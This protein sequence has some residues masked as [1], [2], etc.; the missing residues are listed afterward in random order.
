MSPSFHSSTSS[1]K[2]GQHYHSNKHVDFKENSDNGSSSVTQ[3]R[4]DK[5]IHDEVPHF[6]EQYEDK[7]MKKLQMKGINTN[8]L[9]KTRSKD[10]LRSCNDD[11]IS[12]ENV[13]KQ[14]RKTQTLLKRTISSISTNALN[15]DNN[16]NNNSSKENLSRLHNDSNK[17]NG[18]TTD[19][20][21]SSGKSLFHVP[22]GPHHH[23]HSRD[24]HNSNGGCRSNE[25]APPRK[26]SFAGALFKRFSSAGSHSKDNNNNNNSVSNT[27]NSASSSSSKHSKNL[28]STTEGTELHTPLPSIASTSQSTTTS[29]LRSQ[30]RDSRDSINLGP[31]STSIEKVP[32]AIRSK[33]ADV[34]STIAHEPETV[35]QELSRSTIFAPVKEV[36]TSST[37]KQEPP[38]ISNNYKLVSTASDIVT[39]SVPVRSKSGKKSKNSS[40]NTTGS[41][42]PAQRRSSIMSGISPSTTN[43][44][45]WA[46]S[47]DTTFTPPKDIFV[48]KELRMSKLTNAQKAQT[49]TDVPKVDIN[50]I[51]TIQNDTNNNSSNSSSSSSSSSSNNN[52]AA[53][54]PLDTNLADLTDITKTAQPKQT[55]MTSEDRDDSDFIPKEQELSAYSSDNIKEL[56]KSASGT[57][58]DISDTNFRPFGKKSHSLADIQ[59]WATNSS[60]SL[61]PFASQKST[62]E[63][64]APESW[65]VE[66]NLEK[67]R[68]K[69]KAKAKARKRRL[70]DKKKL[71]KDDLLSFKVNSNR[72]NKKQSSQIDTALDDTIS[73]ANNDSGTNTQERTRY[74]QDEYE[75]SE[76]SSSN[77]SI[78]DISADTHS[79][80]S[81]SE[82][83]EDFYDIQSD[84][85]N[86]DQTP[87]KSNSDLNNRAFSSINLLS[88]NK[89]DFPKATKNVDDEKSDKVEYELERYYKDFSDLDPKRHYAIRVFNTDDTFTTLSC[90]PSTTVEEMI[91]TLKKKFNISVP[92]NYQISLK[93]GKLSK[94]LRPLSKPIL[95]E[96][97][98][99]LLNGY[100][101]S[102]PLHIIGVEDLSF[103][104]KF[105]FHPVTASH[106]TPEQ[107]KRLLRSDFVHVDLRNMNLTTPP[108]IFYQHTAEIESLDVSNNANIFL[109]LEFIESAIKLLSLRIVNVRA[110]KFPTNITEAY[111]LVSLELQRNFIK[112]VPNSIS[113]LWNLTILNLQCN[114]LDRLPQGFSQLKNLQLLD[115]SS[116]RFNRYP[117]VINNCTNLLQIDLSYNKIQVLPESINQLVKV[118]KINIS[119]NKLN[120]IND[121]SGMKNLRTLNLRFNRITSINTNA[122]N[123][124]NLFLTNNRISKFE[125]VV[126]KLRALEIQEN[127]ITI[128]AFKKFYPVDMTSLSLNNAQLASLP[129]KLFTSL[130]RLEKLELNEN[131]LTRLPSE[132]GSL[133]KLVYLSVSRNK[134]ESLPPEFKN[135]K[136]LRSLDLHSNNIRDVFNCMED[137]ELTSLNISSNMFGAADLNTDFFHGL[138]NGSKLTKSLMFFIAADNQFSDQ[139]WPLFNCFI[140][141]KLL[142]LSYNNLSDVS[143]LK[144]EN[145]TELYLSGNGL[146]TLPSD[147]VLKWKQLK[148]L[149]LNGNQL[150]SLPAELSLLRHLNTLDVGSNQLKYNISN[151]HYDW[152]WRDN[153]E[154]KYLNFSGNKRFEIR[155][156]FNSEL[157]ADM[158]D[159]TVLPQLK[160]LGLMDVT[161]NTTRVPDETSNFRLR[162]T[163]STINGMRYGVADTLGQRDYVS[164]KDV[165]F[166]RFRGNDDECLV[167]LHDIKNQNADYGHNI[168]RI[169]RDIYDKILIR[170][171]EK[172]GDKEDDDIRKALR[173]SFLQLNKEINGM[174]S[175]VDSGANVENLTSA[176]LLSGA[177]CTVIYIK[178]TRLFSANIGDCM[179]VL[180][181]NNGDFQQLTKLH[182]PSKRE[183]YERIRISG[184]YVNNGKLDGVV[185]VSRAVG[186]FDLLPHIHASPD[187][188]VVS[189]TKADEMLIVATHNLWDYMSYEVA[190]DIARENISNPM[191]A[192]EEMK[193]HA[194]AYGCSENITILCLALS[195]STEQQN[196]FTLN[197]NSLMTRRTTLED[198]TLRRLQPEIAPPTGNLAVC[199]TDIKSSTFLWEMFP[200]AMRTAIKTHNDIMRRQLRIFGG[201]EVKTEGDAF[202]VTFPTPIGALVW[203]LSV[204]LKLLDAQWPEEIT[205]IQ[206]G[207]LI[208]DESGIKIYQGLSVRMGI[209]WGAP[210][211][212]LDLVT[213][214]MDYLGPVVNKASRVSGIADGGQITLSSDF[215]S[216]FNKIMKYHENVKSGKQNLVDAYGEEIIGEVLEKEITILENIGW[217]FF[218]LGEK[219]L[220]GLETKEFIT[221]VYPKILASRHE[222][223]TEDDEFK[224]IDQDILFRLRSASNKLESILSAVSGGHSENDNKLYQN[225]NFITLSHKSQDSIMSTITEKDIAAFFDHLIVRIESVIA[226]LQLRQKVSNGLI[227]HNTNDRKVPSMSVFELVDKLLLSYE[228]IE[229]KDA[230]NK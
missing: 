150:L 104:F 123:L 62:N 81:S 78:S 51:N 189:L 138:L 105:L 211:L 127:P 166:E 194:I 142:N 221:I 224:T 109:P 79:Y 209:H 125:D 185:D 9:K 121:I 26:T 10:S 214:R 208:K 117:S 31:L 61:S 196:Q 52:K 176:D 158:S 141:L 99:L 18:N 20:S 184:G 73:E 230:A 97:K 172:Y 58:T 39:S 14:P 22:R 228:E 163:G 164:S 13:S 180:S 218:D 80:T 136:S 195:E 49:V 215:V 173:F 175:S 95:V 85:R 156:F 135:L 112:K 28:P 69:K 157:G 4:F 107:E 11:I 160:E 145:L 30:R 213:Q 193:D 124:Q 55:G 153:K 113:R 122:S 144:L 202:M 54:F 118:A 90:T 188:F 23:H 168:S 38:V 8:F 179:A 2:S 40:V 48:P 42:I 210:V 120:Q 35:K 53:L 148:T 46:N 82:E 130:S 111:K 3:P 197:K 165:T 34:V 139:M 133:E 93:V 131:N 219:K 114:E 74:M 89:Q 15:F 220:K 119:H 116:N 154:L 43:I 50:K 1:I 63:W 162:T 203:C 70:R 25:I 64:V 59:R 103:V 106:F 183:E 126:P 217:E 222:F 6:K 137:I 200:D 76:T 66:S 92:T 84:R 21:S 204:Q 128:I 225:S 47:K 132:I 91:P 167:C 60:A 159:L 110:S 140:N 101:K 201:Y 33:V 229:K 181:K 178:G 72:R 102:D 146:R 205:S 16:N 88:L 212:E 170:Q 56:K 147:T 32:N 96:R 129:G 174:L 223:V 198:T 36:T 37:T 27:K 94:I 45:I 171:L 216:E 207:G 68:A 149:M 191:L 226:I 75:F 5:N 199:F 87:Q 44:K 100:R 190:C 29:S 12:N 7:S 169:V 71:M 65:D 115:L 227:V 83:D 77:D 24:A 108:I 134:L 155:S 182:I 161:I 177:C 86:H 67:A 98:L 19:H 41:I 186:F 17:N 143:N 206:E 187:I 152:N 151:F 192:A 57:S